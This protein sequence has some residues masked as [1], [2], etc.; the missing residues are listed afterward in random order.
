MGRDQQTLG[1]VESLLRTAAA[2]LQTLRGAAVDSR[3]VATQ[4]ARNG[5]SEPIDRLVRV[6]DHDQAWARLGR[7]DKLEQLELRGV[8]VLELVDQDQAKLGVQSLAQRRIRL[9]QLDRT[10]DQV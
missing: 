8:H 3:E 2:I 1:A 4:Q 7:G 5:P 9:Q 6:A 10:R